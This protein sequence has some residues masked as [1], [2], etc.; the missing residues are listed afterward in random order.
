MEEAY[1]RSGGN[2]DRFLTGVA[3]NNTRS[4]RLGDQLLRQLRA[5]GGTLGGFRSLVSAGLT[6]TPQSTTQAF[7]AV[8]DTEVVRSAIAENRGF[9]TLAASKP[10]AAADATRKQLLGLRAT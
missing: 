9:Y 10:A 6:A 5:G 1:A 4:R 2:A 3:G 7:G 8:A